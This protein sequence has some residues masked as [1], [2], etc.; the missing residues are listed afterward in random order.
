M[1]LPSWPKPSLKKH[2]LNY[3]YLSPFAPLILSKSLTK[4]YSQS[5]L[6][7][8]STNLVIQLLLNSS[9]LNIHSIPHDYFIYTIY[10]IFI[11]LNNRLLIILSQICYL[12]VI[13]A[14]NLSPYF[15]VWLIIIMLL[16]YYFLK[17]STPMC[18]MFSLT[19]VFLAKLLAIFVSILATYKIPKNVGACTTITNSSLAFKPMDSRKFEVP[20]ISYVTVTT[21]FEVPQDDLFKDKSH[22]QIKIIKKLLRHETI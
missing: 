13:L 6:Y 10:S 14:I 12:I 3:F 7:L 19:C 17:N 15:L 2:M 22:T 5:A 9:I 1:T 18:L 16:L 20:F 21:Q 11:L 4:E 8:Y